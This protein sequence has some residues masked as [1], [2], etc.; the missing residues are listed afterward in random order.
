LDLRFDYRD[1]AIC[2]VVM[3]STARHASLGRNTRHTSAPRSTIF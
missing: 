3:Q 2:G 1:P